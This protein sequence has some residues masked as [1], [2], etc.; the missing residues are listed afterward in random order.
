MM[1]CLTASSLN[2][3]NASLLSDMVVMKA[4]NDSL[5]VYDLCFAI[6]GGLYCLGVYGDYA[7]IFINI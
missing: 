3:E 5:L 4:L 7:D 2:I 6:W 1:P